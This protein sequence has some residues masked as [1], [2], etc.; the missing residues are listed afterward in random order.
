MLKKEL[1]PDDYV[2][3]RDSFIKL[4]SDY[5]VAT[6]FPVDVVR[7]MKMKNSFI[8]VYVDFNLVP[9]SFP[10]TKLNDAEYNRFNFFYSSHN[11]K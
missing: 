7:E 9:V 6:L 11:K 3:Y 5:G 1:Q 2:F 4:V 10:V 8:H